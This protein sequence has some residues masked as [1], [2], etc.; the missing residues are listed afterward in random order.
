MRSQLIGT[1]KLMGEDSVIFFNSLFRP[2][3]EEIRRHDELI[4][5]IDNDIKITDVQDGFKAEIDELDLSLI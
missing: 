4:K 3:D 5:E 2:T 1:I